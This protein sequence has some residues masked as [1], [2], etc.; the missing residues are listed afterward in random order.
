MDRSIPASWGLGMAELEQ[1]YRVE[2]EQADKL[3]RAVPA[4]RKQLYSSVYEEYFR[5][6]PFHPQLTIKHNEEAK[7]QRVDYQLRQILQLIRQ[8]ETFLE[9]GAGDASLSIA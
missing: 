6:L 3:R 1:I 2:V 5:K 9:I 8:A 7:Q 4:E